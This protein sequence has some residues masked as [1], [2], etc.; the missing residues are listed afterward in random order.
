MNNR[1]LEKDP[2][3]KEHLCIKLEEHFQ[4]VLALASVIQSN[5]RDSHQDLNGLFENLL[6]DLHELIHELRSQIEE[7]TQRSRFRLTRQHDTGGRPKYIVSK[8]QI[9]TLRDT[10]MNWKSIAQTLGISERTLFR[11]REEFGLPETFSNIT[12]AELQGNIESI[13]QQTP[14]AGETYI[15]GSL[16]ARKI[17]VQRYRVRESLRLLDPVGRAVRKRVT[18]Q[19]RSYN[20]A[21]PNHLWHMDSNH[22]LIRW[23]FVIHGCIDG[24]S[25]AIIYLRCCT[26][27][28]ASSALQFFMEGTERF[29]VPLRVRADRG[30]ENVEVAKFMVTTR[31]TGRGSFITGNSVHNQRIERLWREVNRVLGALY[32]DLFIVM[33]NSGILDLDNEVHLLALEIVYLP[34][35]NASLQEFEQQWNHHGIRTAG[36]KSPMAL[37]Y[38]GNIYSQQDILVNDLESYGVDYD[39]EV[40]DVETDNNVVV[41]EGTIVISDEQWAQIQNAVPD[42]LAND[43]NY[44][45]N[46]YCRVLETLEQ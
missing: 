14:F 21:A 34:R 26:N 31:G 24:N 35:I 45:I 19:R 33:E 18:I 12:D 2:N 15:R 16:V 11:R 1:S 39:G 20:V 36:H 22:K 17:F 41:P 44:G 10:G 37:W 29:G 46:F 42:P 7:D 28:L 38:S 6:R 43:S 23:K 13:L 8:E 27:N 3:M 32:K 40:P 4:V 30:V 5:G 25:R 9:E